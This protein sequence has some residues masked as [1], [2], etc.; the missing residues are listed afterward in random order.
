MVNYFK[1]RINQL[2]IVNYEG[3]YKKM[4]EL[5]TWG[6]KMS[7][8]LKEKIGGLLK[9]SG[10]QG[11]EFIEYLATLYE[12]N[13][14]KQNQPLM[15]QDFEEMETLTRRILSVFNNVGERVTTTLK[16][17][18]EQLHGKLSQ[19]QEISNM[20]HVKVKEQDQEL[21]ELRGSNEL[22]RQQVEEAIDE[23]INIKS[24]FITK[25]DQLMELMVSNKALIEEYKSKNDTLTGL[26]DEYKQYREQIKVISVEMA[27]EQEEHKETKEALRILQQKADHLDEQTKEIKEKHKSEQQALKDKMAIECEKESLKKDRDYQNMIQSIRDEYN[28]KVKSLLDEIES[29]RGDGSKPEKVTKKKS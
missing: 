8:E 13:Q 29:V 19:Q 23:K 17:R 24:D 25:V 28:T 18:E 16:D 4:S 12:N 7:E 10:L 6:V 9:E 3:G 22:L 15:T 5:V 20:L 27:K 21:E 14:I 2:T 26:L 11:K 1:S